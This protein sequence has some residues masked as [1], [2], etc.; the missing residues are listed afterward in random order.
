MKII[1]DLIELHIVKETKAGL[2]FLL[3]R[4][5]PEEIYPGIWQMVSGKIEKNEKAFQAA[6]RELLEET[7]LLPKKMWIAPKINSF[8]NPDTDT[9]SNIPVFLVQMKSS[10]QV[11]L[12]DEHD[13]FMWVS[14]KKA[15]SLLAWPGQREVVDII[16]EY[17]SKRKN[18]L[19]FVEIP[20]I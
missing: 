20:L 3:L 16:L 6:K 5:S 18:Y 14:G 10:S 7:G 9:I 8:Y 13:A 2:R 11:I 19:K 4:R 15:K 17:W 1:A 12:S